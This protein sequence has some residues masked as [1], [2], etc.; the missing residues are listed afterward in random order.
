MCA[1]QS[2]CR[3]AYSGFI[4]KALDLFVVIPASVSLL[5]PHMSASTLD[6]LMGKYEHTCLTPSK[7][8]TTHYLIQQ[9]ACF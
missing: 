1:K 9:L 6:K 3:V 8:N 7:H 2:F 4:L 5:I